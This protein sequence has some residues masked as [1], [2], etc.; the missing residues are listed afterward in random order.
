MEKNVEAPSF[1]WGFNYMQGIM[2]EKMEA[3]TLWWGSNY[4]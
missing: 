2:E 3:T 1:W 4:M